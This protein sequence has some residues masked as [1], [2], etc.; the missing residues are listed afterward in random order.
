MRTIITTGHTYADIDG[1]ACVFAYQELLSK[2]GM[3]SLALIQGEWNHSVPREV[4]GWDLHYV[5]EYSPLPEDHVVMMD[6]SDIIYLQEGFDIDSIDEVYDHHFGFEKYWHKR[7]GDRCHIEHVGACATLIIEQWMKQ[8]SQS[9]MS[10]ATAQLLGWAIISNTLN[11]QSILTT[12]RD[13]KALAFVENYLISK[14]DWI[15]KYFKLQDDSIRNNLQ[16]SIEW[17]TK[18]VH[19]PFMPDGFYLAQLEM[20]HG[21]DVLGKHFAMID[22]H[23]NKHSD[24]HWLL[25]ILSIKDNVNFLYTRNQQIQTLL[26]EKI[27]AIFQGDFGKTTRLILRKEILRELKA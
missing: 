21:S 18:R 16:Y 3:D 4:S 24:T 1:L 9:K 7:L 12:Q 11:L 5:R 27:G 19:T 22:A 6:V 14:P 23:Y 2:L 10:Y 17:D 26:N 13:I 25:S 15:R 20:W 8:L